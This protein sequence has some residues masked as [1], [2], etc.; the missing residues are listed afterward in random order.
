M[1]KVPGRTSRDR[2]FP[3]CQA[4]VDLHAFCHIDNLFSK[5]FVQPQEKGKTKRKPQ[6]SPP[7]SPQ[8]HRGLSEAASEPPAPGRSSPELINVPSS[9][10]P[11]L[12]GRPFACGPRTVALFQ[13]RIRGGSSQGNKCPGSHGGGVR[14][15]RQRPRQ[16][17]GAAGPLR[18]AE[19]LWAHRVMCVGTRHPAARL[20]LQTGR[21]PEEL[22][23]QMTESK[24]GV[25]GT[26]DS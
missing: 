23:W 19:A 1:Q 10:G 11:L 16:P 8:G 15:G 20:G 21:V 3:K 14:L 13:R 17:S 18:R 4:F 2:C 7:Q 9:P 6:R 25:V 12:A 24:E 5:V 22:F 26:F